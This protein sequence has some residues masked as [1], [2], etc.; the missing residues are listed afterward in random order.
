MMGISCLLMGSIGFFFLVR[1]PTFKDTIMVDVL[2]MLCLWIAIIGLL[3][4]VGLSLF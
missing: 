1:K 4:L 3:E 2:A